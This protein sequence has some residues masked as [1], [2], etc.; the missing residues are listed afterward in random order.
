MVRDARGGKIWRGAS[1]IVGPSSPLNDDWPN[2]QDGLK[3][4]LLKPGGKEPRWLE[5]KHTRKN[6]IKN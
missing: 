2:A 6:F 5:E 3:L 4:A 1:R